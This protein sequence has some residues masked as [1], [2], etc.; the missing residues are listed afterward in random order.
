MCKFDVRRLIFVLFVSVLSSQE[1]LTAEN[2]ELKCRL[3][4]TSERLNS[5]TDENDKTLKS[6]NARNDS[7]QRELTDVRRSL[8]MYESKHI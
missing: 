8:E 4:S 5:L 2:E 6:I 3:E 1:K 7:L